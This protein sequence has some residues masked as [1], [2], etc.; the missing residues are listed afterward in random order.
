M[1][2]VTRIYSART[3]R[4]HNASLAAEVLKRMAWL[5]GGAFVT[6]LT[7]GPLFA[8][9]AASRADPTQLVRVAIAKSSASA[10]A[11]DPLKC[12]S[13]ADGRQEELLALAK[14]RLGGLAVEHVATRVWS[15]NANGNR[16]A[17][18]TF[19]FWGGERGAGEKLYVGS[20][21]V[22]LV[23][24]KVELVSLT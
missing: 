24:C 16:I 13:S 17:Q 11:F 5:A 18:V 6:A 20:G 21:T 9:A 22:D 12:R 1:A 7:L 8:P 10:A 2:H 23:S 3:G 4:A 14:G 19:E 15:D